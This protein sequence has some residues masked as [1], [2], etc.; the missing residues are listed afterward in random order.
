MITLYLLKIMVLFSL[1]LYLSFVFSAIYKKLDYNFSWFKWIPF[2]Y[3]F[4]LLVV[5]KKKWYYGFLFILPVIFFIMPFNYNYYLMNFLNYNYYY[6]FIFRIV[7][8]IFIGFLLLRQ[9]STL[10]DCFNLPKKMSYI[11]VGFFI[12]FISVLAVITILIILGYIAWSTINTQTKFN[13]ENQNTNKFEFWLSKM[14]RFQFYGFL[15]V[16]SI[17]FISVSFWLM[18]NLI[19]GDGLLAIAAGVILFY[20]GII[21][22]FVFLF[23]NVI[24]IKKYE[25]AISNLN[26]KYKFIIFIYF[27]LL[28]FFIVLIITFPIAIQHIKNISIQKDRAE[29]RYYAEEIQK[30]NFLLQNKEEHERE[31][32]CAYYVSNNQILFKR[33]QDRSERDEFFNTDKFCE[34]IIISMVRQKSIDQNDVSICLNDECIKNFAINKK[35]LSY[36][37]LILEEISL[38]PIIMNKPDDLKIDCV[39]KTIDSFRAS[40]YLNNKTSY[41]NYFEIKTICSQLTDVNLQAECLLYFFKLSDIDLNNCDDFSK[42]QYVKYSYFDS[43]INI[44][45]PFPAIDV[46]RLDL[47]IKSKD[48]YSKILNC[49]LIDDDRRLEENY[50]ISNNILKVHCYHLAEVNGCKLYDCGKENYCWDLLAIKKQNPVFCNNIDPE[51]LN[52]PTINDCLNRQYRVAS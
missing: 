40:H 41:N 47:S 9:L 3:L 23:F 52:F 4:L 36:C 37:N 42:D 16:F 13:S 11:V 20:A 38:E 29:Q 19:G 12:P 26:Y 34:N 14:S 2:S 35:D 21:F 49:I 48:C 6:F 39:K 27:I 43:G 15:L 7:F 18:F 32:F 10:F 30:L 22:L 51:N 1:N 17:F 44:K 31:N 46:C 25:C 5:C 45:S 33:I 28:L 8:L 50:Y 24:L